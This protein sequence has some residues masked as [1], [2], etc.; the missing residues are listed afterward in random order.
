M[1]E[2]TGLSLQLDDG[3]YLFKNVDIHLSQNDV[4]V[5][6]GPSGAG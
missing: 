6:R 5:L 2:A 1:L 3:R 4:L